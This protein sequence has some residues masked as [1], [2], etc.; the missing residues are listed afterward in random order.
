M[1]LT[2][3]MTA[4]MASKAPEIAKETAKVTKGTVN[5]S[6]EVTKG[7]CLMLGKGVSFTS[8]NVMNAIKQVAFI[9]TKDIKFSKRNINIDDFQKN[10]DVK[11]VGEAVTGE[12]MK[13]FDQHCKQYGVKY[14]AI[15]NTK[16][17]NYTIFFEGKKTDVIFKVLQE[18]FKD[19]S[20][21]MKN[22]KD[23][24][25]KNDNKNV[26]KEKEPESRESVK[27]KLAFFRN[28]VKNRDEVKVKDDLEKNHQ[29]SER[30]R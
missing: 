19:Y 7:I 14:S 18:S 8:Q 20:D 17:N 3:D 24:G 6:K 21:E 27:A 1:S 4:A 15:Y 25:E 16:E 9:S 12:V 13:Y 11:M 29:R 2:D 10:R 28:W 5:A 22:K 23:V 26:K 30:E